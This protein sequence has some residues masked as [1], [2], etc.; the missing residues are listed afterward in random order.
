MEEK[1]RLYFCSSRCYPPH[2]RG[3]DYFEHFDKT[4]CR[5]KGEWAIATTYP[6]VNRTGKNYLPSDSW[7]YWLNKMNTYT[8][9]NISFYYLEDGKWIKET[10]VFPNSVSGKFV[11]NAFSLVQARNILLAN[12]RY[13]GAW[14]SEDVQPHY[15]IRDIKFKI[16]ESWP[17]FKRGAGGDCEPETWGWTQYFDVVIK[18]LAFER[19]L[20][21]RGKE[22]FFSDFSNAAENINTETCV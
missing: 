17:G 14:F 16:G 6:M 11:V 4:D 1:K 21:P 15:S 2:S 22:T 20:I 5:D 12:I 19:G 10:R 9:E 7:I 13:Y 18:K 3:G 8:F